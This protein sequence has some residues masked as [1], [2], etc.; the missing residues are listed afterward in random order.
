VFG[1][2]RSVDHATHHRH[3]HLLDAGVTPCDLA[4]AIVVPLTTTVRAYA[5]RVGIRLKGK[6]GQ[7]ALDQ[8]RTIDSQRLVKKLG[9]LSASLADQ[10]ASVLVEMFARP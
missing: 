8:I 1:L 3:L 5:T 2:A 9:E 6:A 10:V 7:A 4:T